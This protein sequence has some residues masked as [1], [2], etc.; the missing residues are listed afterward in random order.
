MPKLISKR[1]LCDAVDVLLSMQNPDGGFASY[2]LVRAPHA[3][4]LL[5]PA[6]VFGEARA[7]SLSSPMLMSSGNREHYDR[8]LL[9]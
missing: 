3:V 7:A 4:E 8:V 6:E 9:S 5:N 1:R 2:E